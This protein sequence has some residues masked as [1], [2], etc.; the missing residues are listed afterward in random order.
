MIGL[1]DRLTRPF[2]Y[3]LEPEQVRPRIAA[4]RLWRNG[5]DFDKSEAETQQRIR[6]LGIFVETG[7]D[8]DWIRK[9]Q[10]EDPHRQPLVVGR[11]SGKRGKFE[12]PDR[13]MMSV[14]RLERVQKR[15]SQAIKQADH[16]VSSGNGRRPSL[17]SGTAFTKHTASSESSP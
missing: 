7:G 8:S 6:N 10:P 12:H 17:S 1:L 13:K 3:A 9:I 14:F 2:L 15:P 5:T 4:L 11:S 16:G